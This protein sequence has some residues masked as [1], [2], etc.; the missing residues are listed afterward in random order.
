VSS[1]D[2]TRSPSAA[3]APFDRKACTGMVSTTEQASPYTPCD[4][5]NSAINQLINF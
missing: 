4:K 3:Y 2:L 5:V 1:L